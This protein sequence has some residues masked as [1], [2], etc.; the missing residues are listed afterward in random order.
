MIKNNILSFLVTVLIVTPA[1]AQESS[2][3]TRLDE[4]KFNAMIMRMNKQMSSVNGSAS[5]RMCILNEFD[6]NPKL[7][8]YKPYAYSDSMLPNKKPATSCSDYINAEGKFGPKGEIIAREMTKQ[9]GHK[10]KYPQFFKGKAFQDV[11]R[12][13]PNFSKFH[14]GQKLH[15]WVWFWGSLS[16]DE[17]TCG[18]NLINNNGTNGRAVGE[19]QMEESLKLRRDG[20]RPFPECFPRYVDSKGVTRDG[21]IIDFE[22]NVTCA[23]AILHNELDGGLLDRYKKLF[24]ER[25]YWQ[26]L[27]KNRGSVIDMVMNYPG[28]GAKKSAPA[29]GKNNMS[30]RVDKNSLNISASDK[31][32]TSASSKN[33]TS[34]KAQTTSKPRKK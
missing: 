27:N 30:T 33:Q 3:P 1:L 4:D 21:P 7:Y 19:F 8:S 34:N 9:E 14:K 28:C 17:S 31:Q 13:C 15:F 25:S 12:I 24:G 22:N 26:K 16:L 20:D 32:K 11:E 6:G 29:S 10:L 2:K 23:I 18:V 5:S